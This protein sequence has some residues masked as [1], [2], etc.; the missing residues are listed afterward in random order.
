MKLTRRDF[1]TFAGFTA[2]GIAGGKYL[3]NE[4]LPRESYYLEGD[5]RSRKEELKRGTCGM[6]PAA[7][8]IQ[9]RFVDGIAVKI[10]GNPDCPIGKGKL[11]PKGQMGLELHY[12]PDRIMSPLRRVGESGSQKWE[13]ITWD[14]A[15]TLLSSKVRT[16]LAD[17]NG[18][19]LGVLTNEEQSLGSHLWKKLQ[20]KHADR[21]NLIW[22]NALRDRGI[23]PALEI[24]LDRPEWPVYDLENS[25]FILAFDTPLISG[26]SSP[27]MMIGKYAEFRRGRE[28][29]RGRLVFVGSRRSMD[30]VNADQYV[31]V[32]PYSS[33]ILALGLAHVIVR[34]R[35]YDEAFVSRYCSG[36]ESLKETLLKNFRPNAVA[37]MTGVPVQ[38]INSLA[39][40]FADSLHPIA[41]GERIP[42]PSQAWEQMAIL[43][44]NILKGNLGVEG[45]LNFQEQL[46]FGEIQ[47]PKHQMIDS[48][49]PDYTPLERLGSGV[50]DGTQVPG[51]LLVDKVNPS[52]VARPG[53]NWSDILN[54]VPFVVSFNSYP[55]FV[56]TQADLVLPDLGFLEKAID[57]IHLPALGYPTVS[58]TKALATPIGKGMDTL[59]VQQLL[60]DETFVGEGAIDLAAVEERVER[61]REN[62]HREIFEAQRGLIYDTPFAREW[63]ERMESGGWWSSDNDSFDEFDTKLC[64]QGGW[65]DPYV[66]ASRGK[67]RILK[68]S[69]KINLEGMVSLL[70]LSEILSGKTVPRPPESGSESWTTLTVVPATLLSL[71]ALPYG[72]IP[73][74]LE[75]PEPGIVTGWEPWMELHSSTAEQLGLVSEDYIEIETNN[76]VRK[77]RV[78]IND[79][80]HS[81]IGVIPFGMFGLGEGS[82]V[83]DNMKL[84]FE[85][86]ALKPEDDQSLRGLV[87]K[88]RRV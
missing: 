72:N 58:V 67:N 22:I 6:C 25:D 37:E 76:E 20:T 3:K 64:A 78:I 59:I 88:I 30:G 5:F 85:T 60:L 40:G 1:L 41:I 63:I 24:M 42:Q 56:T 70:P 53:H 43:T 86:D 44:L 7:C 49:N 83:M 71:A 27:T 48:R 17:K 32:T 12:N 84:P 29:V 26:W 16:A 19:G 79:N 11:C 15:L 74:L 61:T 35:R 10:D 9:V 47:P 73:H 69:Q 81:S 36:F 68:S 13:S 66:A 62:F 38:T 52:A 33:A 77:C 75:F 8:G 45:G 14:E 39:R 50:L 31:Q 55:D 57:L 87:V 2:I 4:I 82:W 51:V 23:L 54:R 34:E 21:C 28:R 80:Q 18:A 46:T 65:T